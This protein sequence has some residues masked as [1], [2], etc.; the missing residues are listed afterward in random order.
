[1]RVNDSLILVSST[2]VHVHVQRGC[3]TVYRSLLTYNSMYSVRATYRC[4][5]S[6]CKWMFSS[7]CT[8]WGHMKIVVLTEVSKFT[9]GIRQCHIIYT[10]KVVLF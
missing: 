4:V 7:K 2:H 5:G 10:R 1:M 3:Y 8:P 6:Y 9:S